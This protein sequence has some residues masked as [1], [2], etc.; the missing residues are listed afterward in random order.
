MVHAIDQVDRVLIMQILYINPDSITARQLHAEFLSYRGF[1]WD[2]LHCQSVQESIG[3]LDASRFDVVLFESTNE[4]PR[5]RADLEHLVV[6]FA[7]TPVI[8][9]VRDIAPDVELELFDI[10]VHDTITDRCIDGPYIMRRMRMAQ[11]RAAR[12]SKRAPVEVLAGDPPVTG[13]G[14]GQS[15][16]RLLIVETNNPFHDVCGQ[17][18]RLPGDVERKCVTDLHQAAELLADDEQAFD[19]VLV[20][21]GAVENQQ[22]ERLKKVRRAMEDLPFVMLVLDRSDF[23]AVSCVERGFA[24]CLVAHTTTTRE[25]LASFR[26]CLARNAWQQ[27]QVSSAITDCNAPVSDRREAPRPGANRRRNVRYVIERPV[28]AFAILPDGAPDRDNIYDALSQDFSIGGMGFQIPLLDRLPGRNWLVGLLPDSSSSDD[29]LAYTNVLLRHIKYDTDGISIGA[30][31]QTAED[32]FADFRLTPSIDSESGRVQYGWPR[33]ILEQWRDL[34]VLSRRMVQRAKACPDCQAIVTVGDGCSQCG[35]AAI[36][37][38]VLIHHFACAWVDDCSRFQTEEGVSCPKCQSSGLIVGADFELIKSRY[39]CGD[40][41][42]EGNETEL[43]GS[44]LNCWLRFP[45][46][47]AREMEVYRYD[48]HRLDVL[49]I[50]DSAK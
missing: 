39:C 2:L 24:D 19:G 13:S 47:L 35:S 45:L 27:H 40:C 41:G 7:P 38:R 18:A 6:H 46:R 23:S 22:L 29:E 33:E 11:I 34:N 4:L 32:V 30:K 49:G 28:R 36:D 37:Y 12:D 50:L 1:L 20:D 25:V 15:A 44:C 31:F 3:Q 17:L 43:V 16:M 14:P 5:V 10:G 21:Q 8:A 26:K 42:H 9:L 48:V